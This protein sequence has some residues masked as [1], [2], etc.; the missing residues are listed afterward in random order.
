MAAAIRPR[1][2]RDIFL[3]AC[4]REF[5]NPAQYHKRAFKKWLFHPVQTDFEARN[6][7]FSP[8]GKWIAYE[9]N[10]SGRWEAYVQPFPG[11]GARVPISINGGGQVRWRGDGKELFFLARDERLMAVP[12]ELPSKGGSVEAGAP[13]P[14][15]ATRVGGLV[16][17]SR[18]Q[19][20]VSPEWPAV[21]DEHRSA[22][23]AGLSDH[24]DRELDAAARS[25]RAMT[26]HRSHPAASPRKR[27]IS[28]IFSAASD[29]PI[30]MRR[31]M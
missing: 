12:I 8:D 9:S 3:I 6:R 25:G 22:G 15:F 20:F 13:V 29:S 4:L 28:E 17:A 1:S 16:Q 27:L 30:S 19:Y 14:L 23:R 2:R 18:Q 21:S 10:E 5:L 31:L 7:Q 26:R 11:P 24:G